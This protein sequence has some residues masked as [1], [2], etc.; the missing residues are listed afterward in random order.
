MSGLCKPLSFLLESEIS[1]IID[2]KFRDFMYITERCN[3]LKELSS[4]SNGKG[5][6]VKKEKGREKERGMGST[7]G[8]YK[9]IDHGLL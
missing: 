4:D 5:S 3:G 2:R 1:I 9:W 8:T 6:W 7:S